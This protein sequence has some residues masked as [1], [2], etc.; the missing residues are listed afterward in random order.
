MPYNSVPIRCD[1]NRSAA[2]LQDAKCL[3]KEAVNIRHVLGNLGAYDDIKGR[4]RL[5]LIQSRRRWHM[6]SM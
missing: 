3:F 2:R 1:K 4:I 6:K 5:N